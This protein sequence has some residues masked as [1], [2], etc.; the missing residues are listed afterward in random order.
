MM[1]CVF[2]RIAAHERP[3][4]ILY[5]DDHCVAFQDVNPKAPVHV[6]VIPRRHIESMNDMEP[7]DESVLGRLLTVAARVAQEMGIAGT[8]FRTVINT[9]TDAGQ[10]VFHLHLHV[11]GGR[12]MSWPP[13]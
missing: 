10:T 12:G 5:E 8:G 4:R 6:L 1:G 3:A 9:G 13:G 2:C 7:G 11:L